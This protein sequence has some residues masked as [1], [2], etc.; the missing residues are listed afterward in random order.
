[1]LS[2]PADPARLVL[3]GVGGYGLVHAGRIAKL[4]ADGV[5]HLAAAVD[6]IR[7]EAPEIIAGTDD[8]HRPCG[9]AGGSRT[10]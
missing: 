3:V 4:Q 2:S 7:D 10:D 1:M 8:V 5:V 6:P 9:S